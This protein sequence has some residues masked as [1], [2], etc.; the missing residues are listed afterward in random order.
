MNCAGQSFKEVRRL[1]RISWFVSFATLALLAGAE[2][3]CAQTAPQSSS[4]PSSDC[5]EV[6]PL[7]KRVKV[8][9]RR[10]RDWPE[11]S[12]Y[13]E[14]NAALVATAKVEKRVVFLGDS[15][16]DF[17]SRPASGGFFPG[18]AYINRGV[19]GQ[20]SPQMLIRFKADVI[21]LQPKVIVI[22]AGTNDIA[23][24]TGP[25]TLEQIADNLSSMADLARAH[26]VRVVLAS[27]LP[28]SDYGHR[29]DGRN[30]IQ[31]ERRSP[32]RIVKLNSWIRQYA[33]ENG[34]TY[35]DYF[36][37]MAD[38]SGKLRRDLSE[39]GLHPNA[40]GYAVMAPLAE[41]AIK[42]ALKK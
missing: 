36:S 20:T 29:A 21:A 7:R 5:A 23:G 6:E 24:N 39:D 17:W 33:S 3:I 16:T 26:G 42:R 11:L 31:T 37:V 8:M 9:E 10:L 35:L 1:K 15:I 41:Q 34:Y 40:R 4:S 27:V 14:A 38:Q 12:R 25:T 18:K 19:D 32:D 2:N 22:L 13:R 28:V 30:L